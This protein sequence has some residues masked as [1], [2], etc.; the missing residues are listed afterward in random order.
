M[1]TL[2]FL[3]T[4]SNPYQFF[5]DTNCLPINGYVAANL[6]IPKKFL[7]KVLIYASVKLH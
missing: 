7:F 4:K 3:K 1:Q 6:A 2:S 5:F